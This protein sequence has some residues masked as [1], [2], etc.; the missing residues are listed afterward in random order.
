MSTIQD[1]LNE[2]NTAISKIQGGAQEYRIGNRSW[3][4]PDLTA[5]YQERDRLETK[6]SDSQ[7]YSTFITGFSSR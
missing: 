5:L 1:Q 6:L 3:R 7:G 2:I 4:A